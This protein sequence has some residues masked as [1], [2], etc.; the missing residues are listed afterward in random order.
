[1][2]TLQ[3]SPTLRV[4]TRTLKAKSRRLAPAPAVPAKRVQEMLLEIAF[5]LHATR[6]VAERA[7]GVA[8]KKG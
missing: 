4:T 7:P 5:V 3:L 8:A 1:V 2:T 6:V